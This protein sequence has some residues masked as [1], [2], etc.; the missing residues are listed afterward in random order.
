MTWQERNCLIFVGEKEDDINGLW[1][2]LFLF[3][4][5]G[6]NFQGIW[7]FLILFYSASLGCSLGLIL[8]IWIFPFCLSFKI[9]ILQ[10]FLQF[11]GVLYCGGDFSLWTSGMI[12]IPFSPIVIEKFLCFL[13]KKTIDNM[14]EIYKIFIKPCRYIYIV[15]WVTVSDQNVWFPFCN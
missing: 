11:F 5:L 3:F 14:W 4:Y 1:E 9:F 7:I 8:L 6:F 13:K 12:F 10:S 15:I 2:D